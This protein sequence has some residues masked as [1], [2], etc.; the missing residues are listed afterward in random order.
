MENQNKN[1]E[2]VQAE[3]VEVLPRK[4]D[5]E[6]GGDSVNA[7]PGSVGVK[8]DDLNLNLNVGAGDIHKSDHTLEGASVSGNVTID[9]SKTVNKGPSRFDSAIKMDVPSA[10]EAESAGL[11]K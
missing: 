3:E 7:A 10:P 1:L 6:I 9:N 8:A 2:V 5:K 4:E 11:S